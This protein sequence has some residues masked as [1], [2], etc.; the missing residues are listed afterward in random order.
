MG[1]LIPFMKPAIIV[2]LDDCL[3]DSRHLE[4]YIPKTKNDRAGWD[5]VQEKMAECKVNS[6]ILALVDGLCLTK[7]LELIFITGR[8]GTAALKKATEEKL[9][10]LF[11]R[12][13]IFYRPKN[14][15]K[16]AA[17]IKKE[18][19]LKKIKGKYD[20]LFA[21]DDDESNIKMFQD[22]GLNTLHCQYGRKI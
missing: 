5:L 12:Y 1:L 22:L 11:P 15:Y 17:D 14:N 3:F 4:Q 10:K 8:E 2:D 21:I 9:D 13:Q 16:K 18:I 20:I 7:K 6:H 19:Y